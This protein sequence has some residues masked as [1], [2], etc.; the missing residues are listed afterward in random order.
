MCRIFVKNESDVPPFTWEVFYRP[1]MREY[2]RRILS[3]PGLVTEACARFIENPRDRSLPE[4]MTIL[5]QAIP[6]G[7]FDNQ[8]LQD[9]LSDPTTCWGNQ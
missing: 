5:A 9:Y 8:G 2:F 4:S 1:A 3:V 7:L 6:A